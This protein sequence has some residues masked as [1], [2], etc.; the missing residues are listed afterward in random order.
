MRRLVLLPHFLSQMNALVMDRQVIVAPEALAAFFALVGLLTCQGT[1]PVKR[2]LQSETKDE[3]RGD[4]R[5]PYQSGFSD[6]WSGGRG[7]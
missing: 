6:A 5:G 2:R 7:G 1:A 3:R 4:H